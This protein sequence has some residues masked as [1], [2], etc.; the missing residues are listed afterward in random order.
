MKLLIVAGSKTQNFSEVPEL[1]Y[2]GHDG[3]AAQKA[4]E[5]ALNSGKFAKGKIRRKLITDWTPLPC[6]PT[7][8]AAVPNPVPVAPAAPSKAK[9][10]MAKPA[11]ATPPAPAKAAK[12]SAPAEA[13]PSQEPPAPTAAEEK[14]TGS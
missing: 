1:I 8:K 11:K 10:A 3:V 13:K 12:P 4:A 7:S 14:A 2:W 9:P 6:A 5:E